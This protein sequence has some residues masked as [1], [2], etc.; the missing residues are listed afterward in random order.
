MGR[1]YPAIAATMTIGM[2]DS[3]NALAAL[4]FRESKEMFNIH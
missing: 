2:N 1:C 4:P 3:G